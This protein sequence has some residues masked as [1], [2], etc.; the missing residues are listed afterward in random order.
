M[1]GREFIERA[2]RASDHL[3][4]VRE[5]VA[6]LSSTTLTDDDRV[7]TVSIDPKGKPTIV[8]D[9]DRAYSYEDQEL[10]QIAINTY[11]QAV[12]IHA[13]QMVRSAGQVAVLFGS[14]NREKE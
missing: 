11:N 12:Q 5:Q 3:T 8:V 7:V 2:R 14:L 9:R 13:Q 4:Q 6:E 1:S 10:V